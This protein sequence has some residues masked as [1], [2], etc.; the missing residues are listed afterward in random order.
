MSQ[1]DMVIDNG[2][3]LAVRTDIN[4]A[5]AALVSQNSGPVEPA[6]PFVGMMWLDTTVAPN[7]VLR[8]RNAANNG[9]VSPFAPGGSTAD[10][11]FGTRSSPDRFV[12]NDKL[13]LT[14]AD[15]AVLSD[16]GELQLSGATISQKGRAAVGYVKQ[17]G[18]AAT[19]TWAWR[20]T[21][22][23]TAAGANSKTR[24][25]LADAT[26]TAL[27]LYGTSPAL[28]FYPNNGA[29]RVGYIQHLPAAFTIGSDAANMNLVPNALFVGPRVAA[30]VAAAR[31]QVSYLGSTSQYGLN[32][33]AETVGTSSVP[34]TFTFP[35]SSTVGSISHTATT[36]TYGTSSD[37]RLKEFGGPLTGEEA[38]AIVLAD[39]VRHFTWK[40]DGSTAVGWS[41]QHS[42]TVSH[43]LATPGDDLGPQAQP[44]DA[45]FI[46]WGMDQAKRT[47]Y[48]WAALAAALDRINALEA[49][50][51][52]LEA[53]P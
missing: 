37:E 46:A 34:I 12:W 5:F 6:A 53:R 21:D 16:T 7:G 17:K 20:V 26:D 22:D 24:M 28:G 3:G 44:G 50:V 39:P 29:T 51:A 47:P 9:W 41:A 38:M 30:N 31:V 36:T 48:L 18:L 8:M 15:I 2:P 1:H 40:I 52:A 45:G 13:D 19:D 25:T 10:I 14:G 4:A 11:A 49:R 23:G 35:P 33:V 32:M 43:D 27:G 42:Y